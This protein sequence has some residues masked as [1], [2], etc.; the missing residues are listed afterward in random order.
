MKEKFHFTLVGQPAASLANVDSK[1][2]LRNCPFTLI[3]LL[4]VI[5]IISI[6]MAMLL[7]ALGLARETARKIACASN[8]KQIGSAYNFYATDWK[9]YMVPWSSPGPDNHY[10]YT[11]HYAEY[12]GIDRD[13]NYSRLISPNAD[14]NYWLPYFPVLICPSAPSQTDSKPFTP[15]IPGW[16]NTYTQNIQLNLDLSSTVPYDP[17]H[18]QI[19]TVIIKNASIA[20]LNEDR[21]AY[22]CAPDSWTMTINTHRIGSKGRNRV[23]LDGHVKFSPLAEIKDPFIGI[24]DYNAHL[25]NPL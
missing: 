23:F 4:V 2:A 15:S 6:L 21:Y 8:L 5:A 19:S 17:Y 24:N 3:E 16:D 13:K 7:P 25:P 12:L 9:N 11:H 22:Q 1:S 10:C 14:W 18:G 20:I